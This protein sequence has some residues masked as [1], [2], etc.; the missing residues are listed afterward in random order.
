MKYIRFIIISLLFNA[1]I[2]QQ[3]FYN[4]KTITQNIENKA[5]AQLYYSVFLVENA[6]SADVENFAFKMLKNQ[7]DE[8]GE[9]SCLSPIFLIRN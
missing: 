8:A 4:N 2:S 7:I 1:C 3:P 6:E 9:K 5:T